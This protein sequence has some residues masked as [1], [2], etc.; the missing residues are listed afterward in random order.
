MP[1]LRIGLIPSLLFAILGLSRAAAPLQNNDQPP[2]TTPLTLAIRLEK[3]NEAKK[4]ITPELVNQKD[5]GKYH[6]LTYAVY[7]GNNELIE[8][9]LKAGADANVIEHNGKTALYVAAN[10]NNA[11]GIKLL[12]QYGATYPSKDS[13]YQPAKTAVQSN[14][15]DVLK[16]LLEAHP[17]IDLEA[18]WKKPDR[19]NKR[20]TGSPL[21]YAAR[22]GYNDVGLILL[23]YNCKLDAALWAGSNRYTGESDWRGKKALHSACENPECST[24][25]ISALLAAGCDRFEKTPASHMECET[26]LNYAVASGS[27]SKTK[28]LLAGRDVKISRH[29]SA[30]NRAV[31]TASAHNHTQIVEYLLNLIKVS[32]P[33]PEKWL[34]KY[35]TDSS[36]TDGHNALQERELKKLRQFTPK[37]TRADNQQT[38]KAS[39]AIIASPGLENISS[40]MTSALSKAENITLLERDKLSAIVS[41]SVLKNYQNHAQK[42]F[43]KTIDL[44][45]AENILIISEQSLKQGR[46]IEL[47]TINCQTGMISSRIATSKKQLGEKKIIETYTKYLL[48]ILSITPVGE[49]ST[50]AISLTSI[51]PE[52]PTGK[53]LTTPSS[54]SRT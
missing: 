11:E 54:T 23:K 48:N 51:K 35:H 33:N 18:G 9:L 15:P 13:A 32:L 21:N 44:L 34:K 10:L 17:S 43:H 12:H 19:F 1:D 27:L 46:F 8:A 31:F 6:P 16:A 52:I 14:A 7:T 37:P 50:I 2:R 4:H 36:H 41:E 39:L 30:I 42:K 38:A 22:H 20:L 5:Q 3:F 53:T 29:R 28:T 45:A 47:A 25:F 49:A 24:E 40:L 26:P